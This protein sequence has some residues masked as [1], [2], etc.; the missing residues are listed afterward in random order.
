MSDRY[1]IYELSW[2]SNAFQISNTS[3]PNLIFFENNHYV[4]SNQ[5]SEIL[6]L[7][8]RVDATYLGSEV[9]NNNTSGPDRYL[10][11]SP[12]SNNSVSREFYYYRP[13]APE[14]FGTIKVLPYLSSGLI[15]DNPTEQ[16]G[17]FAFSLEVDSNNRLLVGA[18]RGNGSTG[19]LVVFDRNSDLNFTKSFEVTPPAEFQ[20][21]NM[22]FGASS[23]FLDDLLIVGAPND[24]DFA[25]SVYL[26]QKELNGSYSFLEKVVDEN[27]QDGDLFGYKL[28]LSDS[29]LAT[30]SLQTTSG[31]TG[32]VSIFEI[33]PDNSISYHTEIFASDASTGDE[34]G[35]DLSMNENWL[36][37]GAPKSSSQENGEDSGAAYIYNWDAAS[38]Q[39]V[40]SQ[41]LTP[42]SLSVDDQFGTSVEIS[43]DYIFV[44]SLK[45]DG[46]GV[47]SGSVYIFQYNGNQW[48]EISLLI[49]PNSQSDQLFSTDLEARGNSIFVSSPGSGTHGHVYAYLPEVSTDTWR[50]SSIIDFN[51]TSTTSGSTTLGPIATADGMVVIG[52]PEEGVPT[53]ACGGLQVFFNPAWN[54]NLDFPEVAPLFDQEPPVSFTILEDRQIF[55]YDFNA[56]HKFDQNLTWNITE[57]DQSVGIASIEPSTGLFSF[58][59]FANSFGEQNIRISVESVNSSSTHSFLVSVTPVNDLPQFILE[60]PVSI[61]SLPNAMVG[62]YMSINF[63]LEDIDDLN[64]S[65]SLKS[66]S[67]LPEGLSLSPTGFASSGHSLSGTPSISANPSGSFTEYNFTL[68]LTDESGGSVEQTFSIRIYKENQAPVFEFEGSVITEINLEF[69]EDFTTEDWYDAISS[70]TFS[71]PDGDNFFLSIISQPTEGDGNATIITSEPYTDSQILYSPN[72][73]INGDRSFSIRVTDENLDFPKN[74]EII[75]NIAI[76]SVSDAPRILSPTPLSQAYEDILYHHEFEFFD[77]DENDSISVQLEGLPSWLE[78]S[79]DNLTI[80]GTPTWQDYN[81]GSP[82]VI[83]IT[84][85]D[86]TGNTLERSYSIEVIPNNYPPIISTT[87]NYVIISEDS[88]P[89]GWEPVELNAHDPDGNSNLLWSIEFPPD[90]Q[91]GTVTLA[92]SGNSTTVYFEPEEITLEAPFF[93]SRE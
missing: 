69:Q 10:I 87:S 5:A 25:G 54:S 84:L 76:E 41:K 30:S 32:K 48:Q 61:L 42:E 44:G 17:K 13:S 47:D 29:W 14:N 34:F 24:D 86:Q 71:D 73:D 92:S 93:D 56:S 63:E 68:I 85:E 51:D 45:G 31:G 6:F 39:W 70:L 19:K 77:P 4:F 40:E 28:K 16:E 65:L 79:D 38:G 78:A 8:D 74:S 20:Q 9:F 35:F 50:L 89:I 59:P 53:E 81:S 27:P 90:P 43:N 26:F 57:S 55:T 7:S 46:N 58:S 33:E 66:G 52:S 60:E 72:P 23:T 12:E 1:E 83:F 75:F 37:V 11:F 62:E 21:I 64:L 67:E 2:D 80:S 22:Q 82:V 18:P 88:S 49:P 3:F 36:V 15:Q 91:T